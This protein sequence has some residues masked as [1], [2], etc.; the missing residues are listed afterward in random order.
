M[1]DGNPSANPPVFHNPA[2]VGVVVRDLDR[3]TAELTRIFGIGPFRVVTYPP[4][5]RP[6]IE[7][8]YRGKPGD[9]T[10]R[11][12]FVDLGSVELEIIQPVSGRSIWSDFLEQHGEGIHHIC[13]GVEDI[14]AA[15][16]EYEAKGIE[17]LN[18]TPRKTAD[19][20][21]IAFLS[22]KSTNGV[23]IELMQLGAG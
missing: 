18:K 13:L 4:A 15:L 1:P 16:R 6:D 8:G 22:P 2:Q 10:Y 23:L 7:R 9:F 20:R 19:G 12:A 14:E 21:I 17:L 5:G 3:V 11:Q